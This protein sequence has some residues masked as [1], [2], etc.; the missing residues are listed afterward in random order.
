MA[1]HRFDCGGGGFQGRHR[2]RGRGRKE[3]VLHTRVSERLAED[4]RRMADDLRVPASNLVRNVLEEVFDVVESVSDDVGDLFE[5]LLDEAE[6]ARD[7]VGRARARSHRRRRHGRRPPGA[8]DEADRAAWAAAEAEIDEAERKART[9]AERTAGTTAESARDDV[10]AGAPPPPP[11]QWHYVAAGEAIGPVDLATLSRLAREG[12]LGP[13]TL[14]WT[15]GFAEWR[16][17]RRVRA[18]DD[19]LGPPPVPGAGEGAEPKAGG[20]AGD[21]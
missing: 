3:R 12:E 2:Q 20:P 16:P 21:G 8:S 5:E 17:V 10:A 14:V 4:I 11:V 1:N 18:L 6:A 15:Q 9:T 13:D 19:L 7:R